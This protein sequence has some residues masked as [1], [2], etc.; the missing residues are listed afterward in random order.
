MFGF[1]PLVISG[2][3]VHFDSRVA[4][5]QPTSYSFFE[6][7]ILADADAYPPWM[8][9]LTILFAAG[10]LILFLVGLRRGQP[11][12]IAAPPPDL[13]DPESV[14]PPPPEPLPVAPMPLPRFNKA[15][16]RRVGFRRVG[17]PVEVIVCDAEFK[18]QPVR[19][20]V[21]DRSRHGLRLSLIEKKENGTILQIRPAS[22]PEIVPWQS[23]EVRNAQPGEQSWEMGCR[24]TADPP[25]EVLLLFG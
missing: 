21:V 22:A 4:T 5:A 17:N 18:Q 2:L 16:E 9:W 15:A 13:P 14:A 3:P 1:D 12:T 7:I 20:W 24:F 23:V 6:M 25:W 8:W 19:G 11:K 10:A